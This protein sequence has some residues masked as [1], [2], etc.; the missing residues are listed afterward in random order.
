MYENKVSLLMQQ[1]LIGG[2]GQE[3]K[4]HR[5]DRSQSYMEIANNTYPIS[6]FSQDLTVNHICTY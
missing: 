3:G 5:K 2:V 1:Y 4:K 6:V